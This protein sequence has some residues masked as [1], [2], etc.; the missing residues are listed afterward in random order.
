[1]KKIIVSDLD[2]TFLGQKGSVVPESEWEWDG[3]ARR[4][5]GD[6]RI[7]KTLLTDSSGNRIPLNEV[8]THKGQWILL[9]VCQIG[10]KCNHNE[11]LNNFVVMFSTFFIYM[12][13]TYDIILNWPKGR[14]MLCLI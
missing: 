8:A 5:L 14:Y 12:K 9:V 1:M 13:L 10:W 3:D 6:H 2:G 11:I 4:G 7:P